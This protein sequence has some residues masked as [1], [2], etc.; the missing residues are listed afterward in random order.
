MIREPKYPVQTVM[1]AIE[2][3]NLLAKEGGGQGLGVS[4]FSK[5]LE[6][7]KSTVHRLLDN[8][9]FYGYIEKN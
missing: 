5:E 6:M 9:Q 3:I 4:E 8:L 2:I 1:K 7:G